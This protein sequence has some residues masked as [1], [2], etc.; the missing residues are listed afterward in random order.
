MCRLSILLLRVAVAAVAS[1]VVQVAAA[2]YWLELHL[3]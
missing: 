3:C 1:L 2:A